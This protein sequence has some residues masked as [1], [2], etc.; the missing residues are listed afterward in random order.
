MAA[1]Y[2]RDFDR[3]WLRNAD[4]DGERLLDRIVGAVL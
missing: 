3:R 1:D 2:L 4:H